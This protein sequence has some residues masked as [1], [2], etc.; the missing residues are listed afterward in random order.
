MRALVVSKAFVMETYRRKLTEISRLGADVVAVTPAE[1][2]ESGT[3]QPLESAPD[4]AYELVVSSLRWNG[5]F[6]LYYYPELPRLLDRFRPDLVHV[7]EEPYNTATYLGIRAARRAGKS[8]LFFA[9]QNLRRH[10]PPP[11]SLMERSVY[12]AVS[13]GLA[14]STDAARVLALKGF[15]KPVT[16]VPQ[17]GVDPEQF[18]PGTGHDGPFTVG[19]LNRLIAGKGPMLALEAFRSMPAD[20]RLLFVGDGPMR[21]AV[22]ARARELGLGSRVEL[23]RRVPSAEV[24]HLMHELSVVVLPS[25]TTRAWKEQFGRVLIEGMASGVPVVGSDSGEIPQVIGDAGLIVPEADAAALG[26]ALKRLYDDSELRV[27]LARRG[28]KRAIERYSHRRIAEVTL[29][30]YAEAVSSEQ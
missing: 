22:E 11:F 4:G 9:W 6:H 27:D 12:R 14:G 15:A 21:N 19:F 8:S 28:R 25:V 2:R 18:A 26:E 16:V 20:A 24:P 3:M 1:W 17:F 29:K 30:A 5:H 13:H 7:D 23:R 10:Y